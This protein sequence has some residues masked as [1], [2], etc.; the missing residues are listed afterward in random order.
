MWMCE[1]INMKITAIQGY[2][3][4][5]YKKNFGKKED[6]LKNEAKISS[7]RSGKVSVLKMLPVMLAMAGMQ[8]VAAATTLNADAPQYFPTLQAPPQAPQVYPKTDSRY[9]P[10]YDGESK[11]LHLNLN[12]LY[13]YA[14]INQRSPKL[15]DMNELFDIYIDNGVDW[16]KLKHGFKFSTID[17]VNIQTAIDYFEKLYKYKQIKRKEEILNGNPDPYSPEM[18]SKRQ[19]L[20]A[21]YRPSDILSTYTLGNLSNI[22]TTEAMREAV[23]NS[24]GIVDSKLSMAI[25]DFKDN[26]PEASIDDIYKGNRQDLEYK[27]NKG[28]MGDLVSGANKQIEILKT[29]NEY[30]LENQSEKS[31]TTAVE[32]SADTALDESSSIDSNNTVNETSDYAPPAAETRMMK[33]VYH[34]LQNLLYGEGIEPGNVQF[35]EETDKNI[36]MKVKTNSFT[37]L[38]DLRRADDRVMYTSGVLET[39]GDLGKRKMEMLAMGYA[40]GTLI[41]A[42]FKDVDTDNV[43]GVMTDNDKKPYIIDYTEQGKKAS[44][45]DMGNAIEK[46]MISNYYAAHADDPVEEGDLS[47]FAEVEMFDNWKETRE[48]IYNDAM[49]MEDYFTLD[50]NVNEDMDMANFPEDLLVDDTTYESD[51]TE[52]LSYSASSDITPDKVPSSYSSQEKELSDEKARADI[53]AQAERMVAE[54]EAKE[55][56]EQGQRS[57]PIILGLTALGGAAAGAGGRKAMEVLKNK[58]I[59]VKDLMMKVRQKLSETIAPPEA[60]REK[61]T[62][63]EDPKKTYWK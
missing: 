13:F 40:D 18:L 26:Y 17:I 29:Y 30:L 9:D 52:A 20:R 56:E 45:V 16:K 2:T 44:L 61:H 28:G 23:E 21:H 49:T 57:L 27:M 62:K 3:G 37:T 51:S 12:E 58:N 47:Y 38:L 33:T 5:E 35:L 41:Y 60:Y 24:P 46:G 42:F 8:P 11:Y 15:I 43:Y 36:K 14:F 1:R 4:K 63:T 25:Q 59:N 34:D 7:P 39:H 22:Y 32:E 19:R 54:K 50:I 31:K 48:K 53:I 55:K 10:Q 6:T